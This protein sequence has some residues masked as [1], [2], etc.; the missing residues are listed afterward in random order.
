VWVQRRRRRR[1]EEQGGEWSR[2][3]GSQY[4]SGPTCTHPSWAT[5]DRY[6]PTDRCTLLLRQL[7]SA[8][9]ILG[10]LVS[11]RVVTLSRARRPAAEG[12]TMGGV[13]VEMVTSTIVEMLEGR[14]WSCRCGAAVKIV[15]RGGAAAV[16]MATVR[17]SQDGCR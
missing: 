12:G 8:V 3:T 7:S 6:A 10:L 1:V 17:R 13:M 5:W 15:A 4:I 2:T 9:A 16:L 14:G 11:P